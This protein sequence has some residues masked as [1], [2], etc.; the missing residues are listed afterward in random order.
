MN[1]PLEIRMLATA[2]TIT[3]LAFG[4]LALASTLAQHNPCSK[5]P[6]PSGAPVECREYFNLKKP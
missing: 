3:L 1:L 6:T 5:Y 4:A 2:L